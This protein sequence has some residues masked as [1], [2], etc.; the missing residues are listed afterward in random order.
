MSW[1]AL[2]LAEIGDQI[3]GQFAAFLFINLPTDNFAA[4]VPYG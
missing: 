3:G 2:A 1:N 4:L